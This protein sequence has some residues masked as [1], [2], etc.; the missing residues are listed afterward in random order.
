MKFV[1]SYLHFDSGLQELASSSYYALQLWESFGLLNDDF[2]FGAILRCEKW[3]QVFFFFWP[4]ATKIWVWYHA[5]LRSLISRSIAQF[6]I[7]QCRAVWYHAVSHSLISRSVAQFTIAALKRDLGDVHGLCDICWQS[8]KGRAR[9]CVR[10]CVRAR[11]WLCV[12]VAVCVCVCVFMCVCVR[13]RARVSVCLYVCV[14]VSLCVYACLYA[15]L[16][17]CVSLFFL[18]VC[19]IPIE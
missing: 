9:V 16:C 6:D 4:S 14:C 5:V 1:C 10:A 18:T 15:Y 3:M 19:S 13:A 17:V 12:C 11:A 7:K 8:V 2:P